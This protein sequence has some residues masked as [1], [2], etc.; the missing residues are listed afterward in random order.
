MTGSLADALEPIKVSIPR[1]AAFAAKG[2]NGQAA[3]TAF[4]DEL[5]PFLQT[6]LAC[7]KSCI[8]KKTSNETYSTF[9]TWL[10]EFGFL[11]YLICLGTALSTRLLSAYRLVCDSLFFPGINCRHLTRLLKIRDAQ[12][13]VRSHLAVFCFL[14]SHLRINQK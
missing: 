5:R 8:Q 13:Q 10:N 1:N 2:L 12:P 9:H 3:V 7:N 6:I 4:S 11:Y 14:H